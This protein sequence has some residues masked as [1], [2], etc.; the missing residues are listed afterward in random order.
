MIDWQIDP[1][2]TALIN[3]DLQNMF[4]EGYDHAPSDGPQIVEKLNSLSAIARAAGIT[5]IHTAQEAR[6]DGANRGT[7]SEVVIAYMADHNLVRPNNLSGEHAVAYSPR[8]KIEP[9]DIKLT[10][11]RY[12]AFT[13]TDLDLML[14]KRDID[15][16]IIG[17][18][19]TNVCVDTTVR[20]AATRE[21]RVLVLSDAC[22]N[23]GLGNL[24]ADQVKAATLET[25]RFAFAQVLTADAAAAKIRKASAG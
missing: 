4:V 12:G 14:R 6:A 11:P 10:K 7:C 1:R 16:L 15:T 3:I 25:L 22:S 2:R 17:G 9:G 5:I 19:A 18:I 8:L 13:G 24:T 21:Y 23:R 20:E